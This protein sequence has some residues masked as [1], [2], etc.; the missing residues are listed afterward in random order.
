M[1]SKSMEHF[2]GDYHNS[3]LKCL[4]FVGT[5]VIENIESAFNNNFKMVKF[6]FLYQSFYKYSKSFDAFHSFE[7]LITPSPKSQLKF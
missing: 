2:Q 7:F 6:S 4:L 1:H 5:L 3:R